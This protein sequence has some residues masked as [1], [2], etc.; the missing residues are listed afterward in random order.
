[1]MEQMA[2]FLSIFW[3]IVWGLYLMNIATRKN[4]EHK[5]RIDFACFGT[6]LLAIG[7]GFTM[8]GTTVILMGN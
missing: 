8:V 6:I 5:T 1:M 3:L 2:V 4:M 7:W